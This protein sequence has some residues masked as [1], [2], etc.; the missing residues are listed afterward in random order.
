MYFRQFFAAYTAERISAIL[1]DL[2]KKNTKRSVADF[3]DI[4]VADFENE[5]RK[6]KDFPDK[7]KDKDMSIHVEGIRAN[8]GERIMQGRILVPR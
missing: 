3:L 7:S 8:R 1:G 5:K 4:A 2:E 6:F